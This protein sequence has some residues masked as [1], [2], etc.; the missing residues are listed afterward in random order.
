M[1][2]IGFILILGYLVSCERYEQPSYPKL[3]GM[4]LIV[5]VDYYRIENKDTIN[6]MHFYPGEKCIF[7]N[8]ISPLDTILVGMTNIYFNGVQI[9]LKPYYDPTERT[10]FKQSYWYDI[11]EVNFE[12]PGFI[13]FDTEKGTNM[14]KIIE[15]DFESLYLQTKGQWEQNKT[16]KLNFGS[17]GSERASKYDAVYMKCVWQGP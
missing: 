11:Q 12:H 9:K 6:Q 15:S 10:Y 1:R 4:W 5:K 7:S 16:S 8:D 14:W 13:T 2:T 3:Q 17:I